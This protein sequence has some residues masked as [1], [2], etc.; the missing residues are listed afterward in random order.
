MG[1]MTKTMQIGLTA[2]AFI[3]V[4]C[5]PE[6]QQTASPTPGGAASIVG[7][8]NCGPPEAPGAD[9]VEIRADG[10]VT[11]TPPGGEPGAPMAWSVE[12]NRGSFDG[13]PFTIET[14][15]RLVFDDGFVC[16]RAS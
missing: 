15:D 8:W 14:V 2:L 12:G 5:T 3:V 10:T 6:T 16:T 9:L 1:W 11:V 7:T 13:D 4:A